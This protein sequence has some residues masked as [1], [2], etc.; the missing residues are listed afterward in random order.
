M[1]K[2]LIFVMSFLIVLS[3]CHKLCVPHQYQFS[4]GISTIFPDKD[5]IHVG[6]TLW[7]TCS[8]PLNLKY[9]T[10]SNSDSGNYNISGATNLITDFHLTSPTGKGMQVGAIDSFNFIS[11]KGRIE[12]NSLIP[13]AG[14]TIYFVADTAT[15]NIS[16]GI[17]AKKIGIYYFSII[18]IYQGMKKCD[19][20]SVVI[21]MN[22]LDNHLHYLQDIY[23]GGGPIDQMTATHSYCFK[24]Y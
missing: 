4:G 7:F 1:A 16:F 24:V 14:K 20:F 9:S 12:T 15:Y 18:D 22:D 19:K 5:S 13:D 8:I 3:G 11:L 2:V 21:A 23:Y 10:G 6:D 17:V